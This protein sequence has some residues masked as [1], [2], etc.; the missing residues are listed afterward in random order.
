[1]QYPC[2]LTRDGL[3]DLALNKYFASVDRKDMDATLACFHETA[4]FTIQT[5]DTVH[6]GRVGLRRM[7]ETFFSSYRTIVHRDFQCTVDARNGRIAASFVGDLVNQEGKRELRY[8]T[9]FWR[10]RG[11]KFQEIY[12]YMSDEN[13]L[14]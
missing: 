6:E 2:S 4:L 12:V 7:F 11:E 9:N 10:I 1:M 5:A 3:I 14:V 8:N 13:P